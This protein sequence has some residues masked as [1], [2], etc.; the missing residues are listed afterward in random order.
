MAIPKQADV[1]PDQSLDD[2]PPETKSCLILLG[3]GI[4]P[5][6]SKLDVKSVGASAIA[7]KSYFL[8]TMRVAREDFL[9]LFESSSNATAQ[10]KDVRLH[11]TKFVTKTDGYQRNVFV[12]YAGH[13][14]VQGGSFYLA[15]ASTEAEDEPNSSLSVA[16]LAS[17]IKERAAFARRFVILDC[18]Y[19]GE[20][21]KAFLAPDAFAHATGRVFE[22]EEAPVKIK[23]LKRGTTILCAVDKD[24]AAQAPKELPLTMFSKAFM[25]VLNR[26]H[27]DL[28]EMMTFGDVVGVVANRLP[29]DLQPFLVSPD[30]TR[31]NLAYM[32]R[33]F[34][35]PAAS[36][37]KEPPREQ[38]EL[39]RKS[40]AWVVEDPPPPP[41]TRHW[42]IIV[43]LV[44][45][46][47]IGLILMR[48]MSSPA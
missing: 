9:D 23:D 14:L 29:D 30:H 5:H 32:L 35:N 24:T 16:A 10:L 48:V 21:L 46:I 38:P 12:I 18:C 37:P 2:G 42:R 7:L 33:L 22:N 41:P 6:D 19:A 27:S 39:P 3:A 36:R 13:G 11:L 47:I 40:T 43:A 26:G 34:P 44:V 4:Y 45:I 1:V 8:R 31:G 17:V 15:L 25:D 20:A 28:P